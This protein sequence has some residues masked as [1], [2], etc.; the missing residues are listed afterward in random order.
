MG[1]RSRQYVMP[2]VVIFEGDYKDRQDLGT[3]RKIVVIEAKIKFDGSDA[4][5]VLEYTKIFGETFKGSKIKYILALIDGDA[6]CPS[7]PIIVDKSAKKA[8]EK[9]VSEGRIDLVVVD[10]VA[11]DKSGEKKLVEEIRNFLEI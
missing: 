11:P 6:M 8:L 7:D 1:T 10:G 5:Q 3:S 2:D 9:E 4:K